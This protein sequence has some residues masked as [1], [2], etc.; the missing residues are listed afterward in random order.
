[1]FKSPLLRSLADIGK[2]HSSAKSKVDEMEHL[3]CEEKFSDQVTSFDNT[4]VNPNSLLCKFRFG[5]REESYLSGWVLWCTDFFPLVSTQMQMKKIVLE[6]VWYFCFFSAQERPDNDNQGMQRMYHQLKSPTLTQPLNIC[7]DLI[8][9]CLTVMI[10]T[11]YLFFL[12][13][14]SWCLFWFWFSSFV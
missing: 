3:V 4:G 5:T 7:F 6:F 13:R 9:F 10:K 14:Q 12:P 8:S 2:T 1:M 11:I